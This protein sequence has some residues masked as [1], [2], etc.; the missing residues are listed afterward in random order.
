ML[1]AGTARSQTVAGSF[2]SCSPEGAAAAG[3]WGAGGWA[4][5]GSCCWTDGPG[6]GSGAADAGT[7][8]APSPAATIKPAKNRI[9]GAGE[10]RQG[11]RTNRDNQFRSPTTAD[12]AVYWILD[13]QNHCLAVYGA[14]MKWSMAIPRR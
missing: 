11:R 6:T 10:R 2:K 3:G 13:W 4:T 14:I 1:G 9:Q 5:G 7:G 12:Q 8:N